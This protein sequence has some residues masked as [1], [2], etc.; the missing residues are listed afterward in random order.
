MYTIP[1]KCILNV[2][3]EVV[4]STSLRRERNEVGQ[5]LVY[6]STPN[7]TCLFGSGVETRSILQKA[8]VEV[9]SAGDSL[10]QLPWKP[11]SLEAPGP[12]VLE[13]R[14]FWNK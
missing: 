11:T 12:E 1:D 2:V 14:L 5:R 13:I 7:L 10:L 6:T 9:K 3:R 4:T 8:D